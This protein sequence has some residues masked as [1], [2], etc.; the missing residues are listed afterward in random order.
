MFVLQHG[1]TL[2]SGHGYLA[3]RACLCNDELRP[4]GLPN[5]VILLGNSCIKC[6]N[7]LAEP[8]EAQD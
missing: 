2:R 7:W 3:I 8:K 4:L 6:L 5:I 1:G